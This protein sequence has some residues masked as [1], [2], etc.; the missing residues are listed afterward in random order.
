[1]EQDWIFLPQTIGRFAICYDT[2]AL[3]REIEPALGHGTSS[4]LRQL[5]AMRQPNAQRRVLCNVSYQTRRKTFFLH[6]QVQKQISQSLHN[7][8]FLV[9]TLDMIL[10][11]L[12]HVVLLV[13]ATIFTVWGLNVAIIVFIASTISLIFWVFTTVTTSI[14]TITIIF[15]FTS[16]TRMPIAVLITTVITVLTSA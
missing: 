11:F 10:L 9:I 4:I 6:Y 2:A 3:T 16:L 1:M 12:V 8:L 5:L 7:L 13:T 15:V 14:V